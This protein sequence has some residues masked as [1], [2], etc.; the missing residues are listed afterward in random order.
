MQMAS[1]RSVHFMHVSLAPGYCD[2]PTPPPWFLPCRPPP[3]IPNC[4]CWCFGG[5]WASSVRLPPHLRWTKNM[6]RKSR[7]NWWPMW[8]SVLTIIIITSPVNACPESCTNRSLVSSFSPCIFDRPKIFF[9]IC[10]IF[11]MPSRISCSTAAFL[12]GSTSFPMICD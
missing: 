5:L 10:F 8:G 3:R 12:V 2:S 4:C 7:L 1:I 6:A 9:T 11:A